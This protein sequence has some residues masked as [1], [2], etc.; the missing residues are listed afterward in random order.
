MTAAIPPIYSAN[1]ANGSPMST[2]IEE[3]DKQPTW[4]DLL[5]EGAPKPSRDE[6]LTRA[7]LLEELQRRG[8]DL[9]EKTLTTWEERG[10]VPRATRS[11]RGGSPVALYP[12]FAISGLAQVPTL[13]ARGRKL[14]A[15]FPYMRTAAVNAIMWADPLKPTLAA[16][17][18][19]LT[20]L[21]QAVSALL[22]TDVAGIH[23]SLRDEAGDEVFSHELPVVH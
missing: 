11:R 7:E 14:S 10:Y 5:P 6:L 12:E 15:V 2:D 22:G 4:L 23:V 19:P 13:R 21:A 18:A 16:V 17:R 3:T 20:D 1:G 9:R 8:F